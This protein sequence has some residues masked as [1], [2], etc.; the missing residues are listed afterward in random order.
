MTAGLEEVA[1]PLEPIHS[2]RPADIG[3]ATALQQ[4]PQH[5]ALVTLELDRLGI[6]IP[7]EPA[8]LDRYGHGL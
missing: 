7:K 2:D 8:L 3:K 6:H 1:Q 4:A 5:I